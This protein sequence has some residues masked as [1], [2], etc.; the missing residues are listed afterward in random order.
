MSKQY[1]DFKEIV[2]SN[3]EPQQCTD[4]GL[5]IYTKYLAP[6][7]EARIPFFLKRRKCTDYQ[8]NKWVIE[9]HSATCGVFLRAVC[10]SKEPV[11]HTIYAL[12]AAH[13]LLSREQC[14]QLA[15]GDSKER[16]KR[17]W[18]D[19]VGDVKTDSRLSVAPHG[20]PP[21][22][23]R[24]VPLI[25][26]RQYVPTVDSQLLWHEKF[27]ADETALE[28]NQRQ[29]RE[30]E[31]TGDNLQSFSEYTPIRGSPARR[32]DIAG[33][34]KIKNPEDIDLLLGVRV[35][36]GGVPG[37]IKCHPRSVYNNDKPCQSKLAPHVA[38]C[39]EQP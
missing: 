33:V 30:R 9:N 31:W 22:E 4:D 19:V 38:F 24:G 29:L 3:M 5:P 7:P 27:M 20:Y 14:N 36:C 35:I 1:P 25:N 18:K 2:I 37:T 11:R 23:I 39:C 34:I 12:T 15:S 28:V 10:L 16:K 26:F 21:F 13:S 32:E 17:I 6:K 8:R